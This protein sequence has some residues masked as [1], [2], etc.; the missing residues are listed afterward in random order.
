MYGIVVYTGHETKVMKN[1]VKSKAKLS[2]LERSTNWYI[3]LMVGIQIV[4][5]IVA[6]IFSSIITY[7]ASNTT[8]YFYLGYDPD[9][10][11]WYNLGVAFGTWFI[12]FMNL[13]P[14]SL[15]VTLEVVKFI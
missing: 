9:T 4:V 6:A 1:S 8:K 12:Q 3:V 5:C 11:L 7:T 10:S 2:K 15:M 13:V 14:I